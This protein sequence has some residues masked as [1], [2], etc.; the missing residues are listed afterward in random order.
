MPRTTLLMILVFS[1]PPVFAQSPEL[2]GKT[3]L[4]LYGG[5]DYQGPNGD[6]I[7]LQ[8]SYGW[9]LLDDLLIGGE[10]QWAL[11]EDIAPGENDYRSQQASLVAEK[12]FTGDSELVPYVGVE[13]GFRNTKFKDSIELKDLDESGLVI[14]GRVGV[15]YFL[16]ESVS[17]DGSLSWLLADKEV[18]IVDFEAED[19]YLYPSIGINAVF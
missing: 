2:A 9:F 6:N 19:Q 13:I 15:Q 4:S 16:T 17:I 5:F 18:F 14:G 11:I 3:G 7:Y 1:L 10:F 12:L 8:V